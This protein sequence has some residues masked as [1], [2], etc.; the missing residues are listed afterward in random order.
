MRRNGQQ[1]SLEKKLPHWDFICWKKGQGDQGLT[2]VAQSWTFL[3]LRMSVCLPPYLLLC[4]SQ[5]WSFHHCL[6][7]WWIW[8][9][10]SSPVS[11][12]EWSLT[13]DAHL[14]CLC[15]CVYFSPCPLIC[16][17]LSLSL[18]WAGSLSPPPFPQTFFFLGVGHLL[19]SGTHSQTVSGSG[20]W[21]WTLALFISFWG[22]SPKIPVNSASG[23]HFMLLASL[24]SSPWPPS[25]ASACRL[26]HHSLIAPISV[27]VPAWDIEKYKSP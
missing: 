19:A 4:F 10:L 24:P 17:C 22:M 11:Q 25:T 12:S 23:L 14:S 5:C 15:M 13:Q 7:S 26:P 21:S 27:S 8:M 20:R 9:P 3:L 6:V 18:F 16:F 1:P 2:V